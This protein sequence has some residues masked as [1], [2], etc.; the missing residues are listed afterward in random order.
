MRGLSVGASAPL[1][2]RSLSEAPR[3]CPSLH[4]DLATPHTPL[5]GPGRYFSTIHFHGHCQ[6]LNSPATMR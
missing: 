3:P 1:P 6:L 4:R 2:L 5:Q